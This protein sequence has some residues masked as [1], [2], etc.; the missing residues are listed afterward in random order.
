MFVMLSPPFGFV[1]GPDARKDCPSL[2][3][4][5]DKMS[6]LP[7]VS[8]HVGFNKMCEEAWT[9]AGCNTKVNC[10]PVKEAAAEEDEMDDLFGEDSDEEAAKEAAFELK[11]KAQEAKR[12]AAGKV[13]I[14]KSLL[15]WEVKPLDSETNLDDLF[16]RIIAE[17]KMDGLAWKQ[18]YKKEPVAYGIFKLIVGATIED[19][20][21][22]TDDVQEQMEAMDDMVQSVDI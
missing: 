1:I 11:A 22:S 3:A 21:V 12:L 4:W 7:V 10:A 15:L 9:V 16:K 18:E 5:Y 13:V 14:A 20:K 17:I 19:A 8:R 6:K 2:T